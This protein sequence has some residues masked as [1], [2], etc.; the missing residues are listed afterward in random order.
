MNL[1]MVKMLEL[2]DV[3]EMGLLTKSES[4]FELRKL[5]NEIAD[6]YEQGSDEFMHLMYTLID[7]N[8][9]ANCL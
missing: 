2:A 1:L 8:D 6:N 7:I 4:M 3:I 5:R 9:L